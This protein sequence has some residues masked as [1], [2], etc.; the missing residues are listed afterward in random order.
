MGA[1]IRA[2]DWCATPLGPPELWP[3]SLKTAVRIMLTSRQPMWIGWGPE[4]TYL[5]NE[6]YKAIIGGKHPA[7]LGKPVFE[8]W[9]EI[10]G[11]IG[12]ML[13]TA[14]KGDEG[15]Y[16]EAQLLIMERNGY[17]EETYYTFSYSPIPDDEGGTG[18][19]ICANTDDTER[20]VR[21]R[22]LKLLRQLAASAAQ[23][24]TIAEACETSTR[25]LESN[26]HDLPFA[27][28]YLTDSSGSHLTLSG[29]AGIGADHATAPAVLALDAIAPWPVQAGLTARGAYVVTEA[30][31]PATVLPCGAWDRPPRQVA[32]VP[33]PARGHQA[34]AGLLVVGLNPYHPLDEPYERFI[35]LVA[36]QI[37]TNI[38]NATAYEDERRRAD[39]LAELDRAKTAFFS[40]VSHEFRTPLTLMLGP[41]DELLASADATLTPEAQELLTTTRRNGLRL[42]KLVNNLLDFSRI[43]AG[44]VQANYEPTDLS[45]LTAD[46]ASVFRSA[47]EK[48]GLQLTVDCPPLP[49][50]VPVDRDMWEKVVLNL[51]SNALKFTFDGE[52][53][54]R[55]QWHG[56][57]VTMAVADTGIGIAAG[58]QPHLFERFHRVHGARSRTQEGTGIGLALVQELVRLHHGTIAVVSAPGQ[59]TTFTVSIPTRVGTGLLAR[60][61]PESTDSE[62]AGPKGPALRE[63]APSSRAEA[64]VEEAAGWLTDDHTAAGREHATREAAELP[65]LVL[66]DD[67]ADMRRYVTRLLSDRWNVEAVSNGHD[68]LAAIRRTRPHVVL[69]DVMMGDF[70][71]FALLQALRDDAETRHIPVVLLSAR[72]GEEA[73]LEGLG[74]G[75]DDYLVKPFTARDLLARLEAQLLRVR[76]RQAIHERAALIESVIDNAPI[77]VFLVDQDFKVAQVNPVAAPVFGTIPDLVGRDFE[78][79]IHRIWHRDYAD[80]IVRRFRHTLQ[81]GESYVAHERAE[82]RIDRGITEYYDWRIDRIALP[83][84]RYGV[85][86]YFADVSLQVEARLTIAQ[87]E[88]EFRKL[89]EDL[90]EAN[91]LKDEFLATLSHELRT[92]LNAIL[93]WSHMLRSGALT[94]DVQ[95]RAL[96]AVERNAKAQARL[97]EE[98][99]DVSRIISGK[100][101]IKTEPV[102]LGA[103]V[104]DAVETMRPAAAAKGLSVE[105]DVDPEQQ[106]TVIGDAD[107]LRQIAW[108]LIS[109]AVRF[110]PTGGHVSVAIRP[111]G[112]EVTLVVCDTGEGIDPDFFPHLFERFR[113]ADSTPSRRH[114]GLGLGLAIVRHLA[115]AHGGSVSAVSGGP[116]QGATFIVRLPLR[117]AST[118]EPAAPQPA[119]ADAHAIAGVRMLVADDEPDA[120][121]LLQ[122]VLSS[123]GAQV[124]T[125]RSAGEALYALGREH[126]DVL[127]ADL[128]M[129]EQD[130]YALIRAVRTLPNGNGR[131]PAIAV[132]A[133]ASLRQREGAL[134]AGYNWHLAKPID[135]EQLLAV[136]AQVMRRR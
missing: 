77:G 118:R 120:R 78:E 102:D 31:F 136:I 51:L 21:E 61:S 22:Q 65:R 74:A 13:A 127:I 101:S 85:V 114:G 89:A 62:T 125:A 75:A 30:E 91:R 121:E 45:A 18:G 53:A 40:N 133:Y 88:A 129:P 9:H 56:D 47:I 35:E 23:A 46:L 20:V 44:R 34:N 33:L 112:S 87:S 26:P 8:V 59:G 58:E 100:L 69:S 92:P 130:G 122:Y 27:L 63:N 71:G 113:Q 103:V 29:A 131:V 105:L 1:R 32:L 107:R 68:A 86:C 39:M 94:S 25:A 81:T 57:H 90:K 15:T 132:T 134:E 116:G 108:N 119:L 17:Q 66:A 64:F 123:Y 128:G 72:A 42:S 28:V 52:I 67:N 84:Q 96:D 2:Y 115:E 24:R 135:T 16:V 19:I 43:E 106:L 41:L 97:V 93:G 110:T 36:G 49:E 76:T 124:T 38:G 98:L 109:N 54:V 7:A 50:H 4:L 60:P 82:L 12:P 104:S 48:A 95:R 80:E 5:Y 73:T 126:F 37:I 83:D 70:D 3:A 99:L 117:A 14:M 10:S 6:A 111:D 79:V 55:V 11:E